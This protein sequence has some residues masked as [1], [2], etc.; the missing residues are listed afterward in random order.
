MSEQSQTAEV[1][2]P[3]AVTSASNSR[4]KNVDPAVASRIRLLFS[5]PK[6]SGAGA[7][8]TG[9]FAALKRENKD[10]GL[11]IDQVHS[12]LSTV[13]TF[14]QQVEHTPRNHPFRH[15]EVSG[16]GLVFH[17]DLCFL[18]PTPTGEIGCFVL[19]D[20]FNFYAYVEAIK[21]KTPETTTRV[22]RKILEENSRQLSRI[23]SISG[24]QGSEWKGE[25]E[26]FC[27]S[28]RISFYMLRSPSHAAYSEIFI[29]IL[30]Q[31][32]VAI[33]RSHLTNDWIKFLQ[34]VVKGINN[35][36][37]RSIDTR[38]ALVNSPSHDPEI[39]EARKRDR[40]LRSHEHRP[41]KHLAEKEFAVDQYVYVNVQRSQFDKSF[42]IKR[43][44][45]YQIVRINKLERPWLYY[46]KE[47]FSG[48][49]VKQG[50]YSYQMVPAPNP[51]DNPNELFLIER[52]IAKRH[53]PGKPKEV[54][55]KW[56]FY[57][58]S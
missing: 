15:V 26:K 44:R 39:R 10:E 19:V 52:V 13:P 14:S 16:Q 35:S 40:E 42:D 36:Y 7:A 20:C 17:T 43:T 25:F 46:V 33:S 18:P 4:G 30:K 38:P 29:K 57:P 50:I 34:D 47:C 54:L 58:S 22:L 6:F 53:L 41:N 37:C 12:I 24:D 28:R 31:R 55:V 3:S 11:D 8:L 56:L 32:L 9:F 48:K 45:V 21:D 2:P 5:D 1:S 51:R 23:Q 27:E 49:L